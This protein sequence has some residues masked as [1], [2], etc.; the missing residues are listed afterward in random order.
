MWVWRVDQSII[1]HA[2]QPLNT[3]CVQSNRLPN[4]QC[5]PKHYPFRPRFFC[6]SCTKSSLRVVLEKIAVDA[7]INTKLCHFVYVVWQLIIEEPQHYS[8]VFP[9]TGLGHE[10]MNMVKS[11]TCVF[12]SYCRN[13]SRLFHTKMTCI[14]Q[15]LL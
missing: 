14:C 7:G 8:W 2:M 11:F 15:T 6:K 3:L 5:D 1:I 12:I 4:Q 9:I 10:E 13:N